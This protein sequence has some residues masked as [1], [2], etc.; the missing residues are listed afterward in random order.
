MYYIATGR[1]T[2][3]IIDNGMQVLRVKQETI[4]ANNYT[5]GKKVEDQEHRH[6]V[7]IKMYIF[8]FDQTPK[9]YHG[10]NPPKFFYF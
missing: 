10:K 9:P 3:H 7:A 1:G 8:F 2:I 4:S 5:G 6:R